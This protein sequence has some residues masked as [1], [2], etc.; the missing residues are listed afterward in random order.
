MIPLTERQDQVLRLIAQGLTHAQI[1]Q[2]LFVTVNTVRMFNKGLLN[3]L[4][5]KNQ[6]HA[7]AL[8]VA[9][10]VLTP[11]PRTDDVPRLTTGMTATLELIAR[12]LNGPQIGR[13][14]GRSYHTVHGQVSRLIR[15][16]KA[17]DRGHAV[18]RAFAY[19]LLPL[20]VA[21]GTALETNT[22]YWRRPAA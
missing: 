11:I 14:T 22:Y 1:G 18:M 17:R 8:A 3:R 19:G 21:E 16:L 5:A 9:H 10:G 4:G 12:G 13:Q 7:V 6:A 15:R 20:D 2:K